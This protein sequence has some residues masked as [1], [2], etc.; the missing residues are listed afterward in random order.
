MAGVIAY[1]GQA[2]NHHG[3]PRQGPQIGAKAVS[4][5]PL[6]QRLLHLSQLSVGQPG[7]TALPTRTPQS[8]G[9]T[10]PPLSKPPADTLATHLESTG[11]SCQNHLAGG[12]QAG[13]LLAPTLQCLKVSARGKGRVHASSIHQRE[14]IRHYIMRVCHSIMRESVSA[15]SS[16]GPKGAPCLL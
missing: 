9:A 15:S 4:P 8:L 3:D 1:L 5:G 10:T 13:S 12:E 7:L 6:A 11:D 14:A 2:L 16:P